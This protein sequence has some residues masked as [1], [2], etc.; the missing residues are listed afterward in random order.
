MWINV[1]GQNLQ[2]LPPFFLLPT[3]VLL[4]SPPSPTHV[5]SLDIWQR[6]TPKFRFST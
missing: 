4:Q 6:E 1:I 2:L 3:P 5:R